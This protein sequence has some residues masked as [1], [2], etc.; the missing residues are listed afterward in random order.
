MKRYLTILLVAIT[1]TAA[2]QE[3]RQM[4]DKAISALKSAGTIS[5]NYAVKGSQ[6][7][8]S[9]TIVFG[10]NRY[11]LLSSD[12]KCWYDG[13]TMWTYSPATDEVNITTPDAADLQ[14]SNPYS[15][16]NNFKANYN[17]W[18]AKGQIAGS[19]AIMLRPK[20]KGGEVSQVYLYLANDSHLPQKIHVKLTDGSAYT[21]SLTGF[22]T[23]L[24][25]PV[26]TFQ[27]DQSLVPAG[28]Q[29][30]DLR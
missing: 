18:K 13:K 11:R 27:F 7:N 20:K 14:M 23:N 19:Y 26:S 5:A 6:G 30:V 8:A 17:M 4:L 28:T 12:V 25:L 16:A 2:A 24:N 9:G 21:I 15:A 29:V 22:K 3:P 10:A 1:L